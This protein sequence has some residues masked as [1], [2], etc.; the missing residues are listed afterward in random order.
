M[1]VTKDDAIRTMVTQAKPR[2]DK[3]D[4]GRFDE[5]LKK[6]IEE[7]TTSRVSSP[8]NLSASAGPSPIDTASLLGI[9][10]D[11]I[12]NG[13][14][15]LLGIL[16]EFQTKLGDESIPLSDLSPVI[17]KMKLEKDLLA[18]SLDALTP[19]DPLRDLLNKV[20]VTCSVETEKFERGDYL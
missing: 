10:P 6:T 1:K 13:A 3:R 17:E 19:S 4:A 7:K 20:L 14:E 11:Q 16:E 12:V 9:G 18:P 2:E 5:M 8:L 15:R